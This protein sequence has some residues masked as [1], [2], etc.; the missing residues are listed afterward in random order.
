MELIEQSAKT[1]YMANYRN[2]L[3]KDRLPSIMTQSFQPAVPVIKNRYQSPEELKVTVLKS[4]RITR[5]ID[6]V[7]YLVK[8]PR[9]CSKINF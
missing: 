9:F 4:Q 1:G 2:I 6:D 7:S 8:G 3:R 5:F